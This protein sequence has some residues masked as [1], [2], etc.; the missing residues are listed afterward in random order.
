[1]QG[2]ERLYLIDAHDQQIIVVAT[3]KRDGVILL[4]AEGPGHGV[5]RLHPQLL[6]HRVL[7][8]WPHSQLV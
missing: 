2:E 6:L 3:V 4:A 7:Q 1:M 8:V 5:V